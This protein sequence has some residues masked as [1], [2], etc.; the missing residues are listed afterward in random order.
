MGIELVLWILIVVILVVAYVSLRIVFSWVEHIEGRI[1]HVVCL[2]T[3]CT[4]YHN[5][6]EE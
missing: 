3:H 1:R 2:I 5:E 4:D 6:D